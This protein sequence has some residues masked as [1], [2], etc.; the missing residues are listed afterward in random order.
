MTGALVLMASGLLVLTV[1]HL[2][3]LRMSRPDRDPRVAIVAW[4]L[5]I[6]GAF[7]SV[8]LGV[9]I[10]VL[11]DHA[12]LIGLLREA[13]NCL[14]H[15]GHEGLPSYEETAGLVSL[16]VLGTAAV[17]IAI[18]TARM[19]LARRRKRDHH[20]F[21]VALLSVNRQPDDDIVWLEN[22]SLMAYSVS[23]RPGLV[24]ASRGVSERL[25]P[26]A[27]DATLEH[28]RAHLQGHHHLLLAIAS[29]LATALPFVPLL[30]YA[31]TTLRVLVE[32]AADTAAVDRCG[33][34]AVRSALL[35]FIGTPLPHHGLAMAGASIAHRLDRL[36]TAQCSNPARRAV[37]CGIAGV[38]AALAPAAVTAAIFVGIACP[39]T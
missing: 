9:V 6:V 17:R 30:R 35:A 29:N 7:G 26:D 11:P 18:V 20:R 16:L 36:P 21:L 33:P 32:Y 34:R 24:I 31:S 19:G 12:G 37:S 15:L 25:A 22:D 2:P 39:V 13:G 4:M 38:V 27:R 1:G 14:I 23:G 28:E 3:L 8:A 5:A 10:L